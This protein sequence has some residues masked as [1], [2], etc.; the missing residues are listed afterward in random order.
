MLG[1]DATKRYKTY[2]NCQSKQKLEGQDT[3]PISHKMKY[4]S[5]LVI[6]ACFFFR[7]I[8]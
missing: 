8:K 3:G 4:W 5:L 6:S 1:T 7:D 2:I